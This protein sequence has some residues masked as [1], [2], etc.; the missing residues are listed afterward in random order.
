MA[1]L[2][3]SFGA[4]GSRLLVVVALFLLADG[5]ALGTPHKRQVP[6][7]GVLQQPPGSR[8]LLLAQ[9]SSR[10]RRRRRR[11]RRKRKSRHR[12]APAQPRKARPARRQA[13]PPAPTPAPRATPAPAGQSAGLRRGARV[14]F[15]GRL[16]QGQTAKSGAIYLFARQRS[17]LR[18]MVEERASFRQ[19]ILRSV[20]PDW[21]AQK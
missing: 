9:A 17:P 6:Q 2:M 16:V 11:P 5:E 13:A 19:E 14:E 10:R 7:A 3:A 8:P 4:R 15:D 1:A 20:Y 21:R 18:S 12:R